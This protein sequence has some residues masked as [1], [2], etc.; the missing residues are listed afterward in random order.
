MRLHRLRFQ[1]YHDMK[2]VLSFPGLKAFATKG[3]GI[4]WIYL[5]VLHVQTPAFTILVIMPK[6]VIIFQSCQ[7]SH[8]TQ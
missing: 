4:F 6:L 1:T 3:D 8:N 5:S 7:Y 2:W